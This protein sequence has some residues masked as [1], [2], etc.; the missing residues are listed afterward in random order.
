MFLLCISLLHI[1]SLVCSI[2]QPPSAF[3]SG[4]AASSSVTMCIFAYSSLIVQKLVGVIRL[5]SGYILFKLIGQGL[6]LC[7]F[8][9][10]SLSSQFKI[11]FF[12]YPDLCN[13]P[14]LLLPRPPLLRVGQIPLKEQTLSYPIPLLMHKSDVVFL[15]L[16]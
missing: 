15:G 2:P 14:G 11:Q 12:L 4:R 8:F 10:L 6:C 13:W 9:S 3:Y 1:A 7:V 5:V 16:N